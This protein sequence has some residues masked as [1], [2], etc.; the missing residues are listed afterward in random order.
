MKCPAG[1]FTVPSSVKNANYK[2]QDFTTNPSNLDEYS[3]RWTTKNINMCKV[4][5]CNDIIYKALLKAT[6]VKPVN[7]NNKRCELK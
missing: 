6:N 3:M 7:S 2:L 4:F 5:K 1:A